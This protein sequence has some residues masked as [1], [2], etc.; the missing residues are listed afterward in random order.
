MRIK[1]VLV[2]GASGKIGR[3]LAPALV[4]EG[5]GV[6][7]VQFQSPVAFDG[8]EVV[9]GS[10]SDRDFIRSAL[11]GMDAVC[12][13]STSKEDPEGF[14]DVSIRG[15]L[16][17]LDESRECGHIE[18]LILAGGDAAVGIFFYPQPAPI[19]ES[20]PLAAY[21]G[22]YAFSKVLEETMCNQYAIQYRLPVTILRFS[23]IQDEDDILAY[24]TLAEPNFGGPDW[25]ELAVT[26]EQ[27]AYFE[28][29]MDGVGRL[30]H[31]GGRPYKR[32]VVG[33]R[34]VVDSF[35]LALGNPRAV[36]E[37]FNI[38]AP[39]AFSYDVLSEYIGRKLDLPVVEFE[40]DGC[41][42]FSID[43]TKAR[44][45]LGYQPECDVFKIV[46]DAIAFRQSGR[47]RSPVKYVG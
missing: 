36:G 39:S 16:N 37:T 41:H 19:S 34:D 25:K 23:W 7:A 2:T 13:L 5:Y 28:K 3:N 45:V 8:V 46:D 38:A 27:K 30:A 33:V 22:Y 11:E 15:A 21:P 40:L 42:D 10:V 14:L 32:H 44:S 9:K 12:H 1:N 31:P 6:R 35:L 20:A 18:Q 26:D 4:A 47:S 24:M 17:L 29:G 43:I